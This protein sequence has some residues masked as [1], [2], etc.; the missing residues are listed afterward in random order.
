[1]E[2]EE[3]LREALKKAYSEGY[4]DGFRDGRFQTLKELEEDVKRLRKILEKGEER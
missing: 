1:M 3:I 4:D 2:Q